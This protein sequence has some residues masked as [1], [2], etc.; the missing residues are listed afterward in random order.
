MNPRQVC[1][2]IPTLHGALTTQLTRF[3]LNHVNMVMIFGSND[4]GL[5]I[6]ARAIP[7]NAIPSESVIGLNIPVLLFCLGSSG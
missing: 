4:A 6:L 3:C 1:P 7:E 5:K 2:A